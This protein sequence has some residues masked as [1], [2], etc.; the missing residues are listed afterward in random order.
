MRQ[1]FWLAV[2]PE[3]E[4]WASLFQL[5]FAPSAAPAAKLINK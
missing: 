5:I 3:I 4:S 1:T 2:L